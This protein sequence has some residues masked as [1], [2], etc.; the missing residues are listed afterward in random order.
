MS[1]EHERSQEI[2]HSIV[3]SYIVSGQPVSSSR[4]SRLKKHPVSPATVRN[5][6]ADLTGEGFLSQPHTSAGRVPTEKAFR[7]FVASLD[8]TLA[9]D[10]LARMRQQLGEEETLDGRLQRSSRML[11]AMSH[12]MGIAAAIPAE[13][14]ILDQIDFVSLGHGRVLVVLVTRDRMVRSPVVAVEEDITPEEL[15]VMRNFVNQHFSGWALADVRRELQHR[16]EETKSLYHQVLRKL[17]LLYERGLLDLGLT[18][19]VHMDGASNLLAAGIQT[20]GE[21]LR[22]TFEALEQKAR[23]LELLER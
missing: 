23:V 12:G 17:T 19:E 18:P 1:S 10:L 6:M 8:T 13:S 20:T 15:N 21:E 7:S 4:I 3:K 16:I 9:E 5:V 14:Q 11:R 22:E 2:L